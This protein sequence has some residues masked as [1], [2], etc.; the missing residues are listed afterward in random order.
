MCI[1]DRSSISQAHPSSGTGFTPRAAGPVLHRWRSVDV[2]PF[3]AA[4]ATAQPHQHSQSA[5][6][7]SVSQALEA[8]SPGTIGPN[9]P[10]ARGQWAVSLGL[11]QR[12][13][14]TGRHM[15]VKDEGREVAV[16]TSADTEAAAPA[17]AP[18]SSAGTEAQTQQHH[19]LLPMD[20]AVGPVVPASG[21]AGLDGEATRWRCPHLN[22]PRRAKPRCK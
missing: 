8:Q 22:D 4:Y 13:G 11:Q 17:S 7:Y 19:A 16:Q 2:S 9:T 20:G 6:P 10:F 3:T 21:E 1:R 18:E 5:N 14:V 15:H 12:H